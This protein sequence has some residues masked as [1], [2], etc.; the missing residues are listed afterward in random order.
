M[1]TYKKFTTEEKIRIRKEYSE[2]PRGSK[3]KV[4]KRLAEEMGGSS[5]WVIKIALELN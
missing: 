2:A 3:T 1:R 4:A 5:Q